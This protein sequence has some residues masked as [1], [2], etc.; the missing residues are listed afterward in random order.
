MDVRPPSTGAST[1]ILTIVSDRLLVIE[2]IG[3]SVLPIA[4]VVVIIFVLLSSVLSTDTLVG[5]DVCVFVVA[6]VLNIVLILLPSIIVA[7]VLPTD[8]TDP[9]SVVLIV[10]DVAVVIDFISDSTTIFCTNSLICTD[11]ELVSDVVAID[12]FVSAEIASLFAVVANTFVFTPDLPNCASILVLFGGEYDSR[13]P[14]ID[15]F[16]GGV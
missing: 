9:I 13:D 4:G 16:E 7:C 10:L 2:R 3:D 6:T 11:F 8:T 5:N 12:V 15:V 14:L 1:E